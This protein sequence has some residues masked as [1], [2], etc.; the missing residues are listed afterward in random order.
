MRLRKCT[1]SKKVSNLTLSCVSQKPQKTNIL[2]FVIFA[3]KTTNFA[4]RVYGLGQPSCSTI[5]WDN[6]HTMNFPVC[7]NF[8]PTCVTANLPQ[9]WTLSIPPN[10]FAGIE[11]ILKYMD[12]DEC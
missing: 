8:C 12:S 4:A 6:L 5:Q 11:P 1:A 2:K 7:S 10:A 3:V 9:I